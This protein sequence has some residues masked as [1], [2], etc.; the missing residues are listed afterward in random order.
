[1]R[2]TR[3]TTIF[4]EAQQTQKVMKALEGQKNEKFVERNSKKRGRTF[5][6][7]KDKKKKNG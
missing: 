7:L 2:T 5:L 6:T 1:M 4:A 3:N